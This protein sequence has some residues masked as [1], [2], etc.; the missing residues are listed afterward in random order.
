MQP[1]TEMMPILTPEQA[2]AELTRMGYKTPSELTIEGAV[3]LPEGL[4]FVFSCPCTA[5]NGEPATATLWC[6]EWKPATLCGRLEEPERPNPLDDLELA[7]LSD[8]RAYGRLM[9]RRHRERS[10]SLEN[11]PR[12]YAPGQGYQ[13]ANCMHLKTRTIS[14]APRISRNECKHPDLETPTLIGASDRTPAWCPAL[15][16]RNV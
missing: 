10:E 3:R 11:G 5:A 1:A 14:L 8:S 6:D 4:R 9:A 13:C 15:R 2:L 12:V 16:R 7:A